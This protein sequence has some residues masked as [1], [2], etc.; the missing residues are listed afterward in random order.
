VWKQLFE[1]MRQVFTLTETMSRQ[2]TALKELQQEVRELSRA[3]DEDI[4]RLQSA[5]E[6]LAA[7]LTRVREREESERKI[8]KLELENHLLR[9]ERGLPPTNPEPLEDQPK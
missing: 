5:V 8:L 2:Q 7:E 1:M 4:R 6:R 3:V 9:M